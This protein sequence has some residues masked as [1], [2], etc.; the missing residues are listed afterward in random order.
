MSGKKNRQ[1][2][3]SG[4]T[5]VIVLVIVA[6]VGVMAVLVSTTATLNLR[7]KMMNR[8][9]TKTF[10]S[11][12][13]AVDEVYAALGKMS[14]EAFDE[15]YKSEM[16]L[17]VTEAGASAKTNYVYNKELRKKYLE[18]VC[19]GVG[20]DKNMLVEGNDGFVYPVSEDDIHDFVNMLNGYLEDTTNLEIK[21]ISNLK[22]SS[23]NSGYTDTSNEYD[24]LNTHS[25]TFEDCV[26][27]YVS[28]AG[29][30]S[31][32]TFNG[33]ISSPDVI[34]DF[35]DAD[36]QATS[37]FTAF[38]LIGDAGVRV[39]TRDVVGGTQIEKSAKAAINGG[40]YAGGSAGNGGGLTVQAE[41]ELTYAEG[42][43]VTG[44]NIT[45]NNRAAF[46]ANSA[47]LWC[48]NLAITG[49]GV[50]VSI[51]SERDCDVYVADDMQIDGNDTRVDITGNYF[52]YGHK[53]KESESTHNNSS[54]IILNGKNSRLDISGI[55]SMLLGGKAYIDYSQRMLETIVS[56]TS[57]NG[58]NS[59]YATND[60]IT[61][62]GIQ[63]VFLVP[64]LLMTG[65]D[66]TNPVIVTGNGNAGLTDGN[67]E[68]LITRENFFG[69]EYLDNSA[70]R[71]SVSNYVT[72][73]VSGKKYYY[74]KFKS[75]NNS[76]NNTN[77]TK[78]LKAIV[79]DTAY[80]E[81]K[82]GINNDHSYSDAKKADIIANYDNT[83]QYMKNL[84][85]ANMQEAGSY[86][87]GYNK[88][89]IS[90]VS[91][92]YND[93]IFADVVALGDVV[94][95]VDDLR[96][97]QSIT[98]DSSAVTNASQRSAF[99]KRINE[100]AVSAT[101][102]MNKLKFSSI[103]DVSSSNAK[104]KQLTNGLEGGYVMDVGNESDIVFVTDNS[105][106]ALVVSD[107][108]TIYN[109]IANPLKGK[110]GGIIVA[111]GNVQIDKDFT[112]TII[113]GGTI[114]IE[115]G[116]TITA[117][118]QK[119]T[120]ILN[121]NVGNE[122]AKLFLAWQDKADEDTGDVGATEELSLKSIA[123]LTYKDMVK[124]SDWVKS[125]RQSDED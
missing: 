77:I 95:P 3:N 110:S 16:S 73:T 79:D 78:Y 32:I 99:I 41:S 50:N 122:F 6:F 105:A 1:L 55:R 44:S 97:G 48:N 104:L 125:E 47:Q 59:N 46:F 9:N 28:N 71:G 18:N 88:G 67:T 109:G 98:V 93:A 37:D 116:V 40:I 112:G 101:E 103:I 29:Y 13:D 36:F 25:V 63:E 118:R 120:D 8:E 53:D 82:A 7:M 106:A 85:A 64:T 113:A 42:A 5:F 123:N 54:S 76:A 84:L 23:V 102:L 92:T 75:D 61:F 24:K 117:S 87:S 111:T 15:A 49:N 86:I 26:V 20:F 62:G 30:A 12:E 17:V 19:T 31:S 35:V 119:V 115:D 45:L 96:H 58:G 124:F 2:N 80:D 68:E 69:Y 21:S 83:R 65:R 108:D 56:D 121:N 4:S 114:S 14:M 10:Y 60:S 52:G 27:K 34:V 72:Y 66:V 39:G 89:S 107:E 81:I 11:A 100:C 91:G 33:A 22:I 38:A 51:G 94:I 57:V 90:S 74:L 43:L 70:D